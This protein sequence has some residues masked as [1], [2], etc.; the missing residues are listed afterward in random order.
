[1]SSSVFAQ[2]VHPARS[3]EIRFDAIALSSKSKYEPDSSFRHEDARYPGVIIE[4]AYSQKKTR[5]RRLAE[6]YLLDSDANIRVVVGV[7]I[8]YREGSRKA[9]VSLWRSK[10]FKTLN[11][12]E[13]R[14]ED[15]VVDEVGSIPITLTRC[16][17]PGVSTRL[18]ATMKETP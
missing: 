16:R 2:K 3:S 11:G 8:A 17:C 13:L 6:N 7:D 5:L 9:T 4:V 15:V 12:L 1:M 18:S 10:L 14:V